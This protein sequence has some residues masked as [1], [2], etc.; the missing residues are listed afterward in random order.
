[1]SERDTAEG[2]STT[3]TLGSVATG[4]VVGEG[5][6]GAGRLWGAMV[7]APM[8]PLG[9]ALFSS[10]GGAFGGCVAGLALATADESK[11]IACV[12]GAVGGLLPGGSTAQAAVRVGIKE[13]GE[14]TVRAAARDPGCRTCKGNWL[15]HREGAQSFV[16]PYGDDY[17]IKRLRPDQFFEGKYVTLADR[18]VLASEMVELVARLRRGISEEE[19]AALLKL[20]RSPA[21]VAKLRA[22]LADIVPELES[23]RPGVLM[24]A[25]ADGLTYDELSDTAKKAAR[26]QLNAMSKLGNALVA[27]RQRKGM[28]LIVD[29]SPQTCRYHPDGRIRYW[30]DPVLLRYTDN[31]G[32][33]DLKRPGSSRSPVQPQRSTPLTNELPSSA[34]PGSA[35]DDLVDRLRKGGGL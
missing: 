27:N 33:K 15:V 24:Q 9:V 4:M 31:A 26:G 19:A 14:S 22:G 30:F 23:P 16:R 28:Q 2:P 29:T 18:A 35:D 20:G 12:T 6:A 8:G 7:G 32:R 17:V 13:G 21:E 3:E 34:T 5:A 11:G 10:L 1:M 25:R